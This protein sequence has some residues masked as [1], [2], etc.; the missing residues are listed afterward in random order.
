VV[1]AEMC[2]RRLA[3]S[4]VLSVERGML[5]PETNHSGLP[6]ASSQPCELALVLGLVFA[7]LPPARVDDLGDDQRSNE[8]AA[9]K[10]TLPA[11]GASGTIQGGAA[12][13]PAKPCFV[14]SSQPSL[15]SGR[16]NSALCPS[17]MVWTVVERLTGG[18]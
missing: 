12:V 4:T 1:V 14:A 9:V 6:E 15:G 3:N 8:R 13:R 16:A 7:R 5:S 18:S 10:T 11:Q 2:A 17:R